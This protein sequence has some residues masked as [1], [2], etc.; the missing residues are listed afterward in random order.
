MWSRVDV[1]DNQK[2]GAIRLVG[3][4]VGRRGRAVSVQP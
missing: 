2:E 3:A 1:S 4:T